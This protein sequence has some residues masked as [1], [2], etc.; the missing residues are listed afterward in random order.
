M[1]TFLSSSFRSGI[2]LSVYLRKTFIYFN[3]RVLPG[4]PIPAPLCQVLAVHIHR[5]CFR[6]QEAI[7]DVDTMNPHTSVSAPNLQVQ[8]S[9]T[10]GEAKLKS[11][12]KPH[13]Y[14]IRVTNDHQVYSLFISSLGFHEKF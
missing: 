11:S 5:T 6:L 1:A 7:I 14:D 13:M 2:Y 4:S 9:F 8:A 12:Q 10:T 3:P